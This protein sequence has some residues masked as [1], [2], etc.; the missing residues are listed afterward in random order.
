MS[1]FTVLVAHRRTN[2]LPARG[3][4]ATV[5]TSISMRRGKDILRDKASKGKIRN[6]KNSGGS[7]LNG[8]CHE[9]FDFWFFSPINLTSGSDSRPKAVSYMAS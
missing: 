1:G 2:F 9:I 5:F 4:G 6:F 7:P 3:E 8:Q